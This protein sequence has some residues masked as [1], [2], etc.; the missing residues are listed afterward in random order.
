MQTLPI[1]Q[2]N[3]VSCRITAKPLRHGA[4]L[5]WAT[6]LTASAA[7][8]HVIEA[9]KQSQTSFLA[10][11]LLGGAVIQ[12]AIAIVVMMMPVRRFLVAAIVIQVCAV[13]FWFLAH[14]IGV[15]M[16]ASPVWETWRPETLGLQ[17]FFLPFTEGVTVLF[18]LCLAARTW[19]TESRAWRIVWRFLPVFILL[20][21]LMAWSLLFVINAYA[22]ELVFATFFASAGLPLSLLY[23][24]LPLVGLV[25]LTLLLCACCPRL[26]AVTSRSVRTSSLL[27]PVFLAISLL[28]WEGG[29]T[30]ALRGWFSISSAVSAPA[31]QTTTLTYCS[32]GGNPLAMDLSEPSAEVTRPA[33]IVFYVHG[34]AGFLNSRDLATDYDGAYF[35]QFRDELLKR[36]FAVGS[37]DYPLIPL[38][39]GQE[40]IEDAKCA[41]RFLRAHA[42]ALGID[43]RRIGVYGDSEGGYI[44]SMLGVTGTR[45]GFDVGQYLD[46]SSRVQAVGDLWGFTDLTN[47]S[48]SPSWVHPFGEGEPIARQRANSPVTYVAPNDPPFLII[49]GTDDGLIAIHHSLELYRL[50]DTVKVSTQLVLVQH[51]GHGFNASPAGVTQQPRSDALVH[52]ISN[53]FVRT[54]AI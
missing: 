12:A 15:P 33:P 45:S 2:S 30:A 21:I 10:I 37:I 42:Y 7:V 54:L 31:G 13:L 24:F 14:T 22:A 6:L 44:A 38:A 53:F 34:G 36:G 4:L 9:L 32:P 1:H 49:H 27:L 52:M 48:G 19:E 35:M 50:L 3:L 46:Q 51:G 20:I 25:A 23:I 28:I 17:D 39:S 26:R 29:S 40:M 47:F 8:I 43:S 16:S 18:F 11:L 41:V 5:Y